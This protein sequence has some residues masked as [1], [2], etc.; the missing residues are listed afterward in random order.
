MFRRNYLLSL[1]AFVLI[2]SFCASNAH[3]QVD[4][5]FGSQQKLPS[6]EINMKAAYDAKKIDDARRKKEKAIKQKVSDMVEKEQKRM[7]GQQLEQEK[8]DK[9]RLEEELKQ[10]AIIAAEE[11]IARERAEAIA[12]AA[13]ERAEEEV[14]VRRRIQDE[15]REQALDKAKRLASELSKQRK[16]S[17]EKRQREVEIIRM[18]TEAV[19]EDELEDLIPDKQ[20]IAEVEELPEELPQS[21]QQ[22]ITAPAQAEQPKI[23]K[24][25]AEPA[26]EAA[27]LVQENFSTTGASAIPV[28]IIQPQ[29]KVADSKPEIVEHAEVPKSPNDTNKTLVGVI[30]NLFDGDSKQHLSNVP[31]IDEQKKPLSLA[32]N[33]PNSATPTSEKIIQHVNQETLQTEEIASQE[34]EVVEEVDDLVP[35]SLR[36]NYA[37]NVK[38]SEQVANEEDNAIMEVAQKDSSRLEKLNKQEIVKVAEIAEE[39]EELI[40][41]ADSIEAQIPDEPEPV[42]VAKSEELK[43]PELEVVEETNEVKETNPEEEIIVAIPTEKIEES[44]EQ[45]PVVIE[46]P[47][48]APSGD[49]LSIASMFEVKDT[50]ETPS[51]ISPLEKDTAEDGSQAETT[52]QQAMVPESLLPSALNGLESA[53]GGS[54]RS[55]NQEI[56]SLPADSTDAISTVGHDSFLSIEFTKDQTDLL[57]DILKDLEGVAGKLKSDPAKRLSIVSYASNAEDTMSTARRISLK[58]ALAVRNYLIAKGI[59]TMRINVQALGNSDKAGEGNKDR[60]DIIFIGGS[61]G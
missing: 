15:R 53:A 42:E 43:V 51:A 48:P 19:E 37:N 13:R 9:V 36:K 34:Q 2:Y 11:R 56:A 45:Q 35:L 61:Q 4:L 60:V 17:A 40:T 39:K 21:M 25:I 59:D 10:T 28:E 38:K 3:A 58:R 29:D 27:T 23:A 5:R 12:K 6:I 1:F 32:N 50:S 30:K 18:A 24:E 52:Q 44:E 20:E 41:H 14:L 16:R 46:I 22:K 8:L 33:Y 31:S 26:Q 47:K 57:P 54:S 49:A 7:L 55:P